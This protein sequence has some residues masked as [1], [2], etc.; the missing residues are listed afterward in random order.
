YQPEADFELRDGTICFRGE[1]ILAMSETNLRGLHNA[2]NL[3]A[4]LGVGFARGLSFE[5]M[6]APLR[7]YRALPHRCELIRTLGGVD[8]VNDSKATNLDALEK[9]LMSETQ[10]VV[11]IA[12]GKDKGF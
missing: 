11:L 2:E 1:K 6:T 7:E 8:Y 10:P 9:A 12:G 4:A 3:M 5:K